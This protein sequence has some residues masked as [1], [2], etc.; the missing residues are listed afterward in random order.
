M[1][2]MLELYKELKITMINISK[3]Y[4]SVSQP[5]VILLCREHLSLTGKGFGCH[6]WRSAIGR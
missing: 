1:L 4:C 2:K 3:L 5:G 6:N